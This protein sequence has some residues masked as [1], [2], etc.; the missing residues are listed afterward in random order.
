MKKMVRYVTILILFLCL[1]SLTPH[2]S[3]DF[4]PEYTVEPVTPDMDTG[5]PLETVPV[6]FWDLPPGMMLIAL[7]LS[8]SSFIGFPVELFFFIKVYT[9]LGYRKIAQVT[10]LYNKARNRIYSC[11][12][13]NPGISYNALVR[14]TGIKRGTLRYHLIMLKIGGKITIPES[15]GNPRYFENSGIYSG[16]EKTVLKYLRNKADGRIL[17]L[18]MEN[19]EVT[20]KEIGKELGL[21]VSTVSWRMK[22]LGDEKLIWIQKAGKNMHYGIHPDVRHYLEKYLIPNCEAVQVNPL[23]QVPDS[24]Q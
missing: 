16:L 13:D 7:A 23:E 12:R 9:F 8:V 22:R 17:R 6:D 19:S 10:I 15:S 1:W 18:L 20:R 4:H 3:C 5:T 21:S 24:G 14:M 2:G 11:I